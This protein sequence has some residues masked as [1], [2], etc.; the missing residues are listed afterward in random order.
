MGADKPDDALPAHAR[1]YPHAFPRLELPE[2]PQ[3]VAWQLGAAADR[4]AELKHQVQMVRPLRGEKLAPAPIATVLDYVATAR[5]A[6]LGPLDRLRAVNELAD[7]A[8]REPGEAARL[9]EV[10]WSTARTD[11]ALRAHLLGGLG[12]H[13]VRGEPFAPVLTAAF[14]GF[15]EQPPAGDEELCLMLGGLRSLHAR[16]EAGASLEASILREYLVEAL[17][18]S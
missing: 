9:A 11:Q 4:L 12:R 14:E 16:G 15:A 18:L 10:L 3:W 8:Q 7:H 6:D 5:F 17:S 13:L 2:P 1:G